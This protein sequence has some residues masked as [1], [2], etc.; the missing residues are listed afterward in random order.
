MPK[1]EHFSTLLDAAF[2]LNASKAENSE[3]KRFC[4]DYA[5]SPE[6]LVAQ[7]RLLSGE[8]VVIRRESDES[9]SNKLKVGLFAQKAFE[10]EQLITEYVGAIRP[11]KENKENAN[12]PVVLR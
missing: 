3:S 7:Y 8:A 10:R 5:P 4:A 6:S 1:D 11:F 12:S 9:S 2:C